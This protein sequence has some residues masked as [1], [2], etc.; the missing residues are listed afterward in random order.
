MLLSVIVPVYNTAGE[1]KLEY[2]LNKACENGTLLLE[3]YSSLNI[4]E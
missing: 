1:G 2:C 3:K 4:Q